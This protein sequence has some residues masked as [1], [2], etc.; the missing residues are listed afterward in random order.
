ML[1][2]KRYPSI[3]PTNLLA[4]LPVALLLAACNPS[5]SPNSYPSA[6]VQQASKVYPGVIIGV[7][8][9]TIRVDATLASTT[10]AAAGGITG[11]QAAD[12]TVSALGALGGAVLGGIAGNEFGHSL[13]DTFGYEYIVRRPNGDLLS[14]TQKDVVPLTIGE[15]V[16]LIQGQQARIVKD[17]TVSVDADFTTPQDKPQS[18]NAPKPDLSHKA[19]LSSP[20]DIL[21]ASAH[22]A[23]T[24]PTTRS[25]T[26]MSITPFS[27]SDPTTT[28]TVLVPA[29]TSDKT[30]ASSDT[31]QNENKTSEASTH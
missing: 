17:Y 27:V 26:N 7:R 12:K 22:E 21:P 15:H 11:S 16:L 29:N 1:E 4:I 24:A 2:A 18:P 3:A 23:E 28:P 8:K 9:V 14:V 19:S 20:Q 31:S 5:F 10:G 13:Q 30:P 6:S 25:P